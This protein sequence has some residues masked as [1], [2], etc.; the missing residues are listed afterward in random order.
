MAK[1]TVAC[2][3]CGTLNKVDV[4]RYAQGPKCAECGKP[5]LLDHPVKVEEANFDATVLGSEV[6]VLVDFYADWCGPCKAMA[7]A[8]D[9]IASEKAGTLLVAKVDTDKSPDIS[10]R[11]GIRGIPYFGLFQGGKLVNSAVG[12]VGKK[13]LLALLET[14]AATSGQAPKPAAAGGEK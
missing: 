6:P 1:A 14:E 11:Y 2:Q 4:A 8:L 9:E 3:F 7:P 12:A 5:F 13:G 10:I